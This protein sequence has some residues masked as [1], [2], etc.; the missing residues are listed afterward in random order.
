[1]LTFAL[2]GQTG[3]SIVGLDITVN[4]PYGATVTGLIATFTSSEFSNAF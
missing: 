2:A 1:M 3:S 4:M